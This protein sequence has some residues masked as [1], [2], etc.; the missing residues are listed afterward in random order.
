[1]SESNYGRGFTYIVMIV[2]MGLSYAGYDLAWKILLTI[3]MV[4]ILLK[5]PKII[6]MLHLGPRMYIHE[7]MMRRRKV[8]IELC[9]TFA[10]AP[11]D[12]PE[13]KYWHEAIDKSSNRFAGISQSA[14]AFDLLFDMVVIAAFWLSPFEVGP[15]AGLL[16]GLFV[17]IPAQL[18]AGCSRMYDRNGVPTVKTKEYADAK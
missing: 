1:M 8:L 9:D 17:L 13:A 5:S 11:V 10:A 4:D 12:S 2:L 18:E 15:T 7:L 6:G 16:Y 3:V 14:I